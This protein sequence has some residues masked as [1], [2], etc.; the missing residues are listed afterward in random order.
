[1]KKLILNISLIFFISASIEAQEGWFWQNP[2]PQ[3]NTLYSVEFVN[4]LTGWTVGANG[5]ILRKV[6]SIKLQEEEL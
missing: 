4:E 2:L 1:M 5:T 6:P 3:D